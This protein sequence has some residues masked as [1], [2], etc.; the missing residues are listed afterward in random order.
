MRKQCV[1]RVLG[2]DSELDPVLRIRA[3]VSVDDEQLLALEVLANPVVEC[4][5]LLELEGLIPRSLIDLPG[6]L[7]VANEET[8]LGRTTG[9][10]P[11]F[12]NES[13]CV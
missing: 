11:G 12:G 6:G 7:A 2:N 8:I 4:V 9:E 3:D 5:E 10:L 1:P 13:S